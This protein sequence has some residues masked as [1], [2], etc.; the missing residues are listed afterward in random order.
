MQVK[1]DQPHLSTDKERD[2]A[3]ADHISEYHSGEVST[4][5]KDTEE[6]SGFIRNKPETM[7]IIEMSHDGIIIHKIDENGLYSS[8]SD[9]KFATGTTYEINANA[10]EWCIYPTSLGYF[11]IYISGVKHKID[12]LKKVVFANES[13][14]WFIYF[15]TSA[16]IQTSKTFSLEYFEDSPITSLVYG[17]ATTQELVLLAD[18]RHGIKM[19]GDTH[20]YLHFKEGMIIDK[21]YPDGML[22]NGLSSGSG[23]YT[24]I[25]DGWAYDEDI[26]MYLPEQ[27]NT[28]FLY[29]DG[30]EWR[31][32]TDG[33]DLGLLI[34]GV[35]QFNLNT[36][37]I[38]SL[39]PIVANDA[40]I[41]F[42]IATNNKIFPY[43]KMI[44]QKS[45]ATISEAKDDIDKAY[46]DIKLAGLP[47]PE[48]RPI[49]AIIVNKDGELQ[50][51]ND[52]S[53]YLDLRNIDSWR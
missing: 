13:G 36:N 23:V 43:L 4:I 5:N 15:D 48:F 7:G 39:S 14:L 47:S 32:Q 38:Y 41:T 25:N 51:L 17:N 29:L 10:R 42:F 6:P 11:N 46:Y 52:G 2:L 35:A 49:G 50:L 21:S 28:P 27:T 37:G 8:R 31:I 24:S 33:L 18:E 26:R 3:I 19:D 30:N 45:Y 9:G 1:I 16:N 40:A 53:L 22:I 12:I 44:S 34:N 20:R